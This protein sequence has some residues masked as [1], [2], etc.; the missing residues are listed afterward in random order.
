MQKNKSFEEGKALILELWENTPG[1]IRKH[2]ALFFSKKQSEKMKITSV[3]TRFGIISINRKYCEVISQLRDR[4]LTENLL[5]TSFGHEL[6]HAGDR[7]YFATEIFFLKRID[8]YRFFSKINE[9]H[10][11]FNGA[12]LFS[13]TVRDAVKAMEYK[14]S[15][16][17]DGGDLS[18]P[19][20]S[21]R[22]KYISAG[23]YDAALVR[24]I[25]EDYNVTNESAIAEAEQ[26][27]PDIILKNF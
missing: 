17:G 15:V 26:F 24:M 18:H 27:Y 1:R 4:K 21:R 14:R 3:G 16:N 12:Y 5:K 22:I 19:T 7:Y 11:D 8:K 2:F 25:A 9:V 6:S 10:A 23:K 13:V 20:W